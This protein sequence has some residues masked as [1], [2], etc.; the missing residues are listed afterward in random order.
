[1]ALMLVGQDAMSYIAAGYSWV[2]GVLAAAPNYD[3]WSQR[4]GTFEQALDVGGYDKSCRVFCK[5][6][7]MFRYKVGK[8]LCKIAKSNQSQ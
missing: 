8:I 3:F 6:A 5:C 4:V 7:R 2:I 1:M